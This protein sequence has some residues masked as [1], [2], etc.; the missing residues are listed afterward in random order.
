MLFI[1]LSHSLYPSPPAG[2]K[3]PRPFELNTDI[4]TWTRL[5]T[6]PDRGVGDAGSSPMPHDSKE[7]RGKTK[8]LPSGPDG[9]PPLSPLTASGDSTPRSPLTPPQGVA[10]GMV[11]GEG[12]IV[13]RL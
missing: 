13:C 2:G 10:T 6:R 9:S 7:E 1:S 11:Q 3:F 5:L 8:T 4:V 12:S